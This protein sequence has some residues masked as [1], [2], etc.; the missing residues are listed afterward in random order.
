[1]GFLH[2]IRE[3]GSGSSKFTPCQPYVHR[4]GNS[5]SHWQSQ[6]CLV[7]CSGCPEQSYCLPF[8]WA[9]QVQNSLH[10]FTRTMDL[11]RGDPYKEKMLNKHH[12]A[13]TLYHIPFSFPLILSTGMLQRPISDGT[14]QPKS[15]VQEKMIRQE[16]S[17][18]SPFRPKGL[19]TVNFVQPMLFRDF[20]LAIFFFNLV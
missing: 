12:K 8:C 10:S 16:N 5:C 17:N 3:A 13:F 2:V 18:W 1:M 7:K 15:H 14:N 6:K 19:N 4:A 9:V 20:R 11:E